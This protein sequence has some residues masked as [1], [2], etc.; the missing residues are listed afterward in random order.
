[1]KDKFNRD[2]S[3][4]TSVFSGRMK[5]TQSSRDIGLGSTQR[6]DRYE[7]FIGYQGGP[8]ELSGFNA[9]R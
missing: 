6:S 9:Q 2:R 1:M 4:S 8:S 3:T 7:K 5:S